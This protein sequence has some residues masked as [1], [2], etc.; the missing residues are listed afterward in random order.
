M[1]P[2]EKAKNAATSTESDICSACFKTTPTTL[3]TSTAH[4]TQ[5]HTKSDAG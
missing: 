2:P 4:I 5:A 1:T 3:R